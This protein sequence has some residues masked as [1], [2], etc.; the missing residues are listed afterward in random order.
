[1]NNFLI[2]GLRCP[3]TDDY[4][5]IGKSSSGYER[6]KAH[7]T[8]SHNN[9]VNLWVSELREEGLSP[10]IDVLEE[11]DENNLTIKEQF[12]IQFYEDKGCKLMNHIKYNGKAIYKLKQDILIEQ[13][14]LT[15][16]LEIAKNNLQEFSNI[17]SFIK[18]RRKQLKINQIDLSEMVGITN[19]TL[20]MIE[21][22]S[23]NPSYSTI[24]SLL[25][26]LG[27]KLV[28]ILKT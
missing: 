28:P 1:M 23:G 10:L 17:S 13:E 4:K 14:K 25:D 11:C 27:Y 20:T 12:W 6:A 26:T 16:E 19:R 9:S 8:F 24:V 3:K 5:Y 2:Y 15:K 21:N 7:L 18:K 22:E